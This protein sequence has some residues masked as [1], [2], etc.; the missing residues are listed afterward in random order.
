MVW[1]HAYLFALT[2]AKKAQKFVQKEK[3]SSV[4]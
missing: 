2:L 3:M 1:K 4:V